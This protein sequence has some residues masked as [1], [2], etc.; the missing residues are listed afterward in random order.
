MGKGSDRGKIEKAHSVGASM[1]NLEHQAQVAVF[2]WAAMAKAEFPELR[3]LFSIPNGGARNIVTAKN[4]KAEGVK[5]GIPDLMLAVARHG[6][7]GL[8]IE[9]KIKPNKLSA[10][11]EAEILALNDANYLAVVCWSSHEAI[12]VL[13]KYLS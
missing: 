3:R 2:T 9:M 6:K 1:K 10:L 13:R 11:Q 5:P 8:F 4:L 12:D 7:H